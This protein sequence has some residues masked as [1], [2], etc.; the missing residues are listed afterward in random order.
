M[1]DAIRAM[2]KTDLLTTKE[3]SGKIK[4]ALKK[5]AKRKFVPKVEQKEKRRRASADWT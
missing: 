5:K 1:L 2:Q 3:S 4:A